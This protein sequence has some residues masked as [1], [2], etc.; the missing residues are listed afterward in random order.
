[1]S[2]SPDNIKPYWNEDHTK[3]AILLTRGMYTGWSIMNEPW[4]AYD[5][6][7]VKYVIDH[8]KIDGWQ[9]AF[10][11]TNHGLSRSTYSQTKEYKEF[12]KF[13]NS[14]GY[15]DCFL[16]PIAHVVVVW[17]DAGR[18]W[19]IMD[20]GECQEVLEFEDQVFWYSFK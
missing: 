14:I 9:K 16:P 15:K 3:Y 6:R 7:I 4:V 12:D 17:I 5:K 13:L 18:K 1:M 19:R 11:Y 20:G 10:D 8:L 2:I